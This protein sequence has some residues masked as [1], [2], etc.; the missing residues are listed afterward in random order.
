MKRFDEFVIEVGSKSM[1]VSGLSV[2]GRDLKLWRVFRNP[3]ESRCVGN[4]HWDKQDKQQAKYQYV[5][6]N[7]GN[8]FKKRAIPKAKWEEIKGKSQ[9]RQRSVRKH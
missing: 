6:T 9:E 5:Q 4:P 3:E 7:F 1:K 8:A 2:T